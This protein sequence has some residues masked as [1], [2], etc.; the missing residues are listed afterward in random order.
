LSISCYA[1]QS[2]TTTDSE[3]NHDGRKSQDVSREVREQARHSWHRE[4]RRYK[5]E[6]QGLRRSEKRREEIRLQAAR[7][8]EA[9]VCIVRFIQAVRACSEAIG[10]DE[11]I[12][13]EESAGQEILRTE[14]IQA[15]HEI[16]QREERREGAQLEPSLARDTR[17]DGGRSAGDDRR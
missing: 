2:P 1:R 12:G 16:R 8:E 7:S 5:E 11:E 17:G 15:S 13:S 14:I 4:A 9:H 10:R 6:H 3:E